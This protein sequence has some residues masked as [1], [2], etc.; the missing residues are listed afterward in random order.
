MIKKRIS[1]LRDRFKEFD[2][3]GYIIP[4][5]DEFFSEYSQKDRLK[6]ISNFTGSAGYAI[7]LKKKNYLFVDDRYTIQAKIESGKEFE[8]TNLTKIENC[9][10]FK[11]LTLGL[12][13]KLF[14]S[15]QTKNFFLKYNKVKEIQL[16]LIDSIYSKYQSKPKPFFSLSKKTVGQSHLIKI[17]KT[18]A[19]IRKKR[20][21]YLFISAP[22]NV[23]WL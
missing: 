4:K 16:N 13:P 7:I 2:I 5:N 10:L 12:D 1:K 14:T 8:I 21:N 9:K 18:A 20:S 19:F 11:N 3:D 17:Q 6:T 22:E 15:K 23:A